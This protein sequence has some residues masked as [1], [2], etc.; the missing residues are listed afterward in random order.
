MPAAPPHDWWLAFV[1]AKLFGSDVVE[2]PLINYR[3]HGANHIGINPLTVMTMRQ[4]LKLL[5]NQAEF[6]SLTQK[7]VEHNRIAI[8][9]LQAAHRLEKAHGL[10]TERSGELIGWSTAYDQSLLL[11][12][13]RRLFR[14]N[15]ELFAI[16]PE[17][18][19]SQTVLVK[20]LSGKLL[21]VLARLMICPP[22]EPFRRQPREIFGLEKRR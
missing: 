7:V 15:R 2:E 4:K 16:I 14:D 1:A 11:T 5:L 18:Y 17:S 8:G 12:G 19:R 21:R 20:L 9:R 22:F 6:F 13:Y 3:V 10:D